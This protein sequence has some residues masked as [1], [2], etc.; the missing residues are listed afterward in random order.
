[1]QSKE[2]Q[3]DIKGNVNSSSLNGLELNLGDVLEKLLDIC[4]ICLKK[5]F[6]TWVLCRSN[7]QTLT[8][9][10]FALKHNDVNNSFKILTPFP[11]K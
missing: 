11:P 6:A 4:Q 5:A 3:R 9:L 1:M 7:H 10:S 8:Y 2:S